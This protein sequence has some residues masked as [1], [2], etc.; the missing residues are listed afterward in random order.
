MLVVLLLLTILVKEG[1][2]RDSSIFV[3]LGF[4]SIIR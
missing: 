4:R 2:L 3:M 1:D